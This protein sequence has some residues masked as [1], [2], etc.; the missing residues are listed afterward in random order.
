MTRQQDT[1]H[2]EQA[3]LAAGRAAGYCWE[4]NPEGRGR[5]TRSYP[6]DDDHVDYY[7]GRQSITDVAGYR[8]PQ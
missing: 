3:A 2:D 1:A 5:C 4:L 6:H 7:N 8:W